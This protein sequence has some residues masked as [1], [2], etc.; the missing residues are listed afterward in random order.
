MSQSHATILSAISFSSARRT[1][2]SFGSSLRTESAIQPR[3]QSGN[4][5]AQSSQASWPLVPEYMKLL[6]DGRKPSQNSAVLAV[7]DGRSA[8]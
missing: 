8:G 7:M 5:T 2:S 1:K 6:S 4:T 3:P